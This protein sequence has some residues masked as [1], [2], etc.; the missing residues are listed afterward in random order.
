MNNFQ[1]VIKLQNENNILLN[2]LNEKDLIIEDLKIIINDQKQTIKY[3][4]KKI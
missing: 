2:K 1:D 3:L 4:L